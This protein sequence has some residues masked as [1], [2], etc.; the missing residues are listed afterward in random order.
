M[1]TIIEKASFL[2]N[3]LVPL[4]GTIKAN[5]PARW[6]KMNAQQMIEHMRYAFMEAAGKYDRTILTAEEHLPKMYAFMMSEKPFRENTPNQLLP[7]EPEPL[8]YED[9]P[10][11]LEA[12]KTEIENFFHEF[13]NHPDKKVTNPFFGHLN[14]EE[15]VQL[16]HKHSW[17]H[18]K[19]FGVENS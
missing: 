1:S 4:L 2:R 13:A 12:L 11:A 8:E 14:F 9:I 18:L 6:G 19:Q 7:N 17:H 16:L 15:W 5:E 3:K 10:R